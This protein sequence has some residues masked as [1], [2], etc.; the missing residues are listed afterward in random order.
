MKKTEPV[1]PQKFIEDLWAARNAYTLLAAIELDVFTAI[2]NGKLTAADVARALKTSKTGMERLL[3]ALTALGYLD[4]K[5][6]QYRLTPASAAFLV[7]GRETYIGDLA[8]ESRMTLPGWARLA[9][10]V[11]SGHPVT[12][13]DSETEGR[14][15]FPDLVRAIFPLSYGAARSLVES[16]PARKTKQ[17]NR[18]LDVA[19]GAA[20]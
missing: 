16:L 15:F 7:R 14:K 9:D 19:A 17:W 10:V 6:I 3:D 13:A 5:G 11:R 2:A 4:K 20:P 12:A 18:I 8:Q 1:T